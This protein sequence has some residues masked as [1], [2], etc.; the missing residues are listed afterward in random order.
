MSIPEQGS[1]G[2]SLFGGHAADL[3]IVLIVIMVGVLG[4]GLGVL[5]GK[6][7]AQGQEF[8]IEQLP[9]RA[10]P[11]A[12]GPAAVAS[13]VLTTKEPE[14]P[15][16]PVE[17]VYVASKNGTKYYLPTCSGARR[18]KEEN[19]VWFGTVEA[20]AAAGYSAAANCPGL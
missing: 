6:D 3:L 4:F 17:K 5:A 15:Q 1:G 14:K 11:T 18:I 20:A 13:A 7:M 19:Q 2:K 16:E 9:E 10:V 12:G 8:W